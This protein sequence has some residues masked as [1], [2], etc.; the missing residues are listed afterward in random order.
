MAAA[1]L[2]AD[3]GFCI[4]GKLRDIRD[5]N[6]YTELVIHIARHQAKGRVR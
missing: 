6:L 2:R 1:R 5:G 3:I 4:L